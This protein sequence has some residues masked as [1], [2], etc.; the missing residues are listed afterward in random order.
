MTRQILGLRSS[1]STLAVLAG[2][3]IPA[4]LMAQPQSASALTGRITSAE[5]GAMEGVL[6]SAKRAGSTITVTV[7]T[8]AKGQYSFPRDRLEPGKYSV[9]I[10]A[11]GYELPNATPAQIDI[12]QRQPAA[13]DL[14]L[15]KTKDLE[16]QLSSGEWLQSIPGTKQFK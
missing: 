15:V 13:L 10:R 16:R 6:I 2:L 11:I 5:E 3:A 4:P 1:I 8:D 14:N 12:A 7:A 9:W